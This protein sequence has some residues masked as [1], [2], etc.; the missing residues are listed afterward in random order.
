MK[1]ELNLAGE[2][3]MFDTLYTACSYYMLSQM[4]IVK[5]AV[6]PEESAIAIKRINQIQD[7][8]KQIELMPAKSD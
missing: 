7:V 6:L 1:T 8:L 3:E 4:R 2:S 5:N